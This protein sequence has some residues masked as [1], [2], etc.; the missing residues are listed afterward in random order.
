M[1]S[2][3]KYY[4]C[5]QWPTRGSTTRTGIELVYNSG[6]DYD[7]FDSDTDRESH[8]LLLD[9]PSAELVHSDMLMFCSL[10]Y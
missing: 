9:P 4:D 6:T 8:L 3:W 1:I 7:S 10:H 5:L 2:L